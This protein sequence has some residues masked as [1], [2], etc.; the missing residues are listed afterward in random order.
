MSRPGLG[1]AARTF[2]APKRA[3]RSSAGDAMV[4]ELTLAAATSPSARDSN[5]SFTNAHRAA[6]SSA[7][8]TSSGSGIARS[9]ASPSHD[10]SALALCRT[11]IQR[12][13]ASA[14]RPRVSHARAKREVHSVRRSG[15]SCLSSA[16]R[17]S[18]P[19]R[20]S[21]KVSMSP[22][23]EDSA[24]FSAASMAPRRAAGWSLLKS[25]ASLYDRSAS[26]GS[27]HANAAL[28]SKTHASYDASSSA[29]A[30]RV[31]ARA[32]WLSPAASASRAKP[33][34]LRT[35]FTCAADMLLLF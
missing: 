15:V 10:A 30:S 20:T 25:A 17:L 7:A 21:T 28:P 31:S 18:A 35:S 22:S 29:R 27:P 8:T 13:N 16:G 11:V 3:N 23:C 34:F 19:C 32:F 24:S 1:L 9:A 33:S 12:A 2:A 26:F 14:C 4:V 5:S 6:P